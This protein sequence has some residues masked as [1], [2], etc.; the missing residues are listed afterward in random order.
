MTDIKHSDL[1][2]FDPDAD[3]T[4]AWKKLPHLAQAGT[5]CFVTWRT[6]D[7][8]PKEAIE[9]H[10]KEREEL[11]RQHQI[12]PGNNWKASLAQLKPAVRAQVYW[13]LFNAWDNELD[14]ASGACVLRNPELSRIVMDSLL[15]FD[16]DRYFLTD[17]V[18]MPNHVHLIAAFRDEEAL[19]SQC[20][21][22]KHFT[23]T[24]INRRLWNEN[25][26]ADGAADLRSSHIHPAPDS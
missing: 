20:T 19:L 22:W 7:S 5:L 11:L 13:S 15:H 14:N 18:I 6:A 17:A 4:M 26:S 24:M 1:Q 12:D 9:R 10:A 16:N 21:S 8:L 23:G 3:H 25:N 2:Y